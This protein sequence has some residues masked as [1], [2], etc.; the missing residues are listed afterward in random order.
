MSCIDQSMGLV[1]R[2]DLRTNLDVN[3]VSALNKLVVCDG[4]TTSSSNDVISEWAQLTHTRANAIE[5]N[6]VGQYNTFFPLGDRSSVPIFD[7]I[8]GDPIVSISGSQNQLITFEKAGVY[9]I[10]LSFDISLSTGG[11]ANAFV[12]LSS[13]LA[14]NATPQAAVE[15]YTDYSTSANITVIYNVNQG[16]VYQLYFKYATQNDV[17]MYI[18]SISLSIQEI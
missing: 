6:F 1:V 12:A 16:D 15:V 5:L 4:A 7:E 10:T 17:L 14:T 8:S 18:E 2:D 13:E 3:Y 11:P 9:R